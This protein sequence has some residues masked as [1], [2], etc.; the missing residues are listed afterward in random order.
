LS[1]G[2]EAH[3]F[4]T[5]IERDMRDGDVRVREREDRTASKLKKGDP[6][7]SFSSLGEKGT[8]VT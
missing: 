4:R 5:E 6:D 1:K 7:L 8:V 3:V 2:E